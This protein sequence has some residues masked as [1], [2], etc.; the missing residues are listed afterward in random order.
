MVHWP[1]PYCKC[2]DADALCRASIGPSWLMYGLSCLQIAARFLSNKPVRNILVLV[3]PRIKSE[4][5][6][7]LSTSREHSV[8]ETSSFKTAEEGNA[9][10]QWKYKTASY[11]HSFRS[12]NSQ[13]ICNRDQC[14][15]YPGY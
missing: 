10:T 14:T 15:V 4:H 3:S 2:H 7:P 8:F 9:I 12:V 11:H 13:A 1:A 6:W 5:Q